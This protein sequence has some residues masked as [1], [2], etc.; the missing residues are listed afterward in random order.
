MLQHFLI[1]REEEKYLNFVTKT[2]KDKYFNY[3]TEQNELKNINIIKI[4]EN[5]YISNIIYKSLLSDKEILELN[6]IFKS[7]K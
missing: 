3:Y 7:Y 2:T 6:S 1:F 5:S 4:T